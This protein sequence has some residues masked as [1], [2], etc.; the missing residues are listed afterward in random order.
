MKKILF[1]SIF[2]IIGNKSYSQN[3]EYSRVIDTTLTYT[4][5]VEL[6]QTN[7]SIKYWRLHFSSSG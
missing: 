3:L 5:N 1:L 7:K 6:L 2:F 4:M